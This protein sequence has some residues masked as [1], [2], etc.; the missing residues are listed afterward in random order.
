MY[1]S[2]LTSDTW[3]VIA[4]LRERFP[5]QPVFLIGF[6]LGGNVALKLAGEYDCQGILAG[7]VGVS[8]PIDLAA[9]VHELDRKSNFLYS[10]RFLDRLKGRIQRKSISS[11]HLYRVDKLPHIHSIWAFDDE[12]TAPLFGFGTAENY[13]RTQSAQNFIP[14]IRIPGLLITAQDDPL[15]PFRSYSDLHAIG[16]NPNLTL[17]APRYGG[18]LGFLSRSRPRF[19]VDG[20]IVNWLKAQR[21]EMAIAGTPGLGFSS[22]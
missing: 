21:E 8:A 2:G 11:P 3:L 12:F 7:V 13:Y 18:H 20:V 4:T 19:W 6:S 10:R 17:V 22:V 14:Q 1:H 5:S 15:V 9:C 16:E